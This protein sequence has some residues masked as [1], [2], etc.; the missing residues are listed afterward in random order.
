V[1]TVNRGNF[2]ENCPKGRLI[3]SMF[4]YLLPVTSTRNEQNTGRNGCTH[5][6][7]LPI[8]SHIC[9]GVRRRPFH[10]FLLL[11]FPS[12]LPFPRLNLPSGFSTLSFTLSFTFFSI[13]LNPSLPKTNPLCSLE[14]LHSTALNHPH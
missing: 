9:T 3:T 2:G 1:Y 13:Q 8:A 11:Y 12:L 10:F 4:G 14:P 5:W 6:R 7:C